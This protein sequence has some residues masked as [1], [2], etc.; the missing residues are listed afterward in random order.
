[1]S[2]WPVLTLVVF[3]PLLGVLALL[4]LPGDAHRAIRW[5]ALL[6]ALA[7]LF[8]SFV[9]LGYDT[10]GPEFQFREELEWIPAFGM[11]YRL[12]VDGISVVLVLLTTVLSV[13]A[14]LYSWDPIRTRVKEYYATMLLLMVGMLG[15]FVSLD[16]FLF[17]VFWEISLI[18]MYLVIG[19][20]GGPRRIYATVKFVIYTLVG[21]LLML[22][23]ILA[24][25]IAHGAETGTFTFAYEQLRGFPYADGL[26]ALAFVA[27]FLAFAIKVPMWPLHTWLPDAHVE[28]PTAGSIILA[29]VLLK[30]GGYG[31]LRFSL[32]LLPDA[33]MEFAPIVIALSI[34]AIIYGALVS[35]VQPDLKKL[36]AY[37]SVSHMGFVTLGTFVFNQQGIS[38]AVFQMVS[39]GIT[40]GALFLLVGVIYERTH[41]R[42]IAHMGGLNARLPRYAALFGL[43]TFASIGLPGLSGFVGEFLV[44]LGAFRYSG[45]VAAAAMV[46]VILSAVYM[47]W[48]FQRVFF[49]VPSDW[50]RRWWPS[51]TD[52][53]RTEWLSLAPLV[54]LVVGL[55]VFP[56][57]VL[58]AIEA[59]VQR[60]VEA[61]N[62]SSGLTSLS[63]PW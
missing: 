6:A 25:A 54:L 9:L 42:M 29:A 12:G 41:D 13:V 34:V 17:Y 40:T 39:H 56:G 32:P 61:V 7:S 14:I 19:I 52:L 21:S 16:L 33:A 55:G 5:V 22:V 46:V 60:I 35:M 2:D 24:V 57:P 23:A 47:L 26:Q 11:G 30:L 10:G 59:P 8:F 38:G 63:L 37:S 20:W 28:A 53:T 48:M 1:V 27:F 43:F 3:T 45:W 50:M 4:L 18:P 31:F 36:I 62:G 49:A 15:V 51:L 44:V 58:G